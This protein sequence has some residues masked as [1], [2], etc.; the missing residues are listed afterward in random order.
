MKLTRKDIQKYATLKEQKIL[1]EMPF[2]YQDGSTQYNED[3]LEYQKVEKDLSTAKNTVWV[4][5]TRNSEIG[6]NIIGVY[7]SE[8]KASKAQ[9]KNMFVVQ[10]AL[11]AKGFP[12]KNFGI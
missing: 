8:H 11:N 6:E 4:V 12:H 2:T 7:D 9:R 10:V 3:E 5:F 1:M